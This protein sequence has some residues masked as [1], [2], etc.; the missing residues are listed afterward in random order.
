MAKPLPD[1][2]TRAFRGL[3]TVTDP[4]SL[5]LSWLTQ[6]DNVDVTDAGKLVKRSGYDR[7]LT[8]SFA[9]GYSTH[10]F[11]RMYVVAGLALK[12]M[13]GASAAVTIA[14]L[15][16]TAPMYWGEVN[17]Q[18]FFNNGVDS[19]IILGDNTVLPWAWTVPQAPTLTAGA[20]SLEPGS[21]SAC[22]TFVLPDGRETGASAPVEIDLADGQSLVVSDIPQVT[23][24]RTNVYLSPANSEVFSL[25]RS[26]APVA[27]QWS[28]PADALGAELDT[29][30]LSPL[31]AGCGP[32]AHWRGS[33][34]AARYLPG[35]DQTV[36][37]VSKPLAWHLF[38]LAEDFIMVAGRVLMLAEHDQ[39]L[40]IGTDREVRAWD[41][42]RQTVLAD[43]GV[44]AGQHASL[45]DDR[46]LMFWTRRGWCRALPFR[47]LMERQAS[48][49]PGVR[50]AGAIVRD[51]GQKRAV[52]AL[53]Q[54]G[55]AF[56][57]FN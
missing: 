32:V 8:G 53:Q 26:A 42:E 5:G 21:Y 23:G 30:F 43:Y 44:I 52:V 4:R 20:G 17:G 41:G 37:W 9:G 35:Q 13:A 39:A 18:V 29:M 56:N 11:Q 3:N 10:D 6:A 46:S 1:Q 31:P 22:C 40:V 50:A 2:I 24:W 36:I 47:N 48:V 38:H 27:V 28:L 49:A 51:G 19:G 54:G 33:M 16:S 57:S 12:A 25:L 14:T 34:W 45:D 55:D 15:T 7:T